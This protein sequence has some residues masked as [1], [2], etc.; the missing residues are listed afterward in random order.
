MLSSA[1]KD[2]VSPNKPISL[3]TISEK[4]MYGKNAWYPACLLQ[5]CL[6]TQINDGENPREQAQDQA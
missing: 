5:M 4:C 2:S 3:T 6:S 1:M